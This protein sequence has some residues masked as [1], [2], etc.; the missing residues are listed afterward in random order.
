MPKHM[1]LKQLLGSKAST[2]LKLTRLGGEALAMLRS[3]DVLKVKLKANTS[4]LSRL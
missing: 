4:L 1:K 3:Y 2:M